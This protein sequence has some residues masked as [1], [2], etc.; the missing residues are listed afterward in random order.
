[1]TRLGE[2]GGE[3]GGVGSVELGL[4]FSAPLFSFLATTY[5][6]C[7]LRELG[8]GL[9]SFEPLKP[10]CSMNNEI[11]VMTMRR[12]DGLVPYPRNECPG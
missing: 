8:A 12:N 5:L 6:P 7:G 4:L 10:V 11:C 1:M 3:G 2:K 9:V